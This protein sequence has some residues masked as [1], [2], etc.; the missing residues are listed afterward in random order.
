MR[1][2]ARFTLR[3]LLYAAFAAALG[4]FATLPTYTY[5]EPGRAVIKLSISHATDRVEPCITLTPEELAKLAANMRQAESCERARRPLGV[6]LLVDGVTLHEAEAEASGLWHDG[7]AY[8]YE[9]LT[10]AAGRHTV[11]V[12]LRDS[13]RD[14]GWDHAAEREL[15]LA[16][17]R[18][19]A[20]SFDGQKGEFEFR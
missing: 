20:I 2:V 14:E 11:A 7:P 15:E 18:Y 5:S 3:V 12:R 9:T 4:Y 8:V 10:V 6:A 16:P 17:G 13:A 19:L 1:S